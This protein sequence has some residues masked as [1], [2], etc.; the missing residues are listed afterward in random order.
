MVVTTS[1]IVRTLLGSGFVVTNVAR[2]PSYL[3]FHSRRSDELGVSTNYLLALSGDSR[4]SRTD[5]AGLRR[6]ATFHSASLVI[7]GEPPEAGGDG[8]PVIS[9]EDFLRK[10]GGAISSYLPLET[11]YP[12]QLTTLGLNKLPPGL[13][14]NADDLFE[15]YVHVGLQYLLQK[16]VVRYGQDRR[17]ETLPD[18]AVLGSE[19]LVLLYDCKAAKDG[20]DVSRNSIRQFG[21]YVRSFHRRYEAYIGRVHSFLVISGYFQSPGTFDERSRDLQAE[22]QVP[23]VFLTAE[24]MGKIIQLLVKRPAYRQSLEWKRIFAGGEVR[25]SEVKKNLQ[26]RIKDGVIRQ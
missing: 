15:E 17:F 16:R 5:I 7:I 6:T 11:S 20:Y 22:C 1:T 25:A 4:L 21:D 9:P 23:L 3:V 19:S 10:L 2:K 14:G 13:K 18:G 24:E 26:A 12:E 8:L